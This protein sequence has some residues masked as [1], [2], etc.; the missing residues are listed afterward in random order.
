MT[1]KFFNKTVSILLTMIFL[2]GIFPP[3]VFAGPSSPS[4]RGEVKGFNGNVFD[5]SFSR[6]D[7]EINPERWLAEAKLGLSQAIYSWELIA[8]GLYEDPSL[9]EE[10]KNSLEK[11]GGE[12]L[13]ARFSDWLIGRFFGA[14]AEKTILEFSQNFSDTQKKYSWHLDGEGNVVFDD[15]TGDPLVIRPDEDGR[16]FSRDIV[17]WRNDAKTIINASSASHENIIARLF[18]ELLAYIPPEKRE[19]MTALIY[20]TVSVKNNAIKREFENIA[21]REERIFTSRRTRDIWS[22]RNKSENEAAKLFTEKLIAETGEICKAGIEELNVR[23]EQAEAGAGD[24]A[25]LGEEWL[26]LYREQF[27][28][29]LK[30]WEEAEERFFVRRIEWEQDSFKL[31]SEGE[32]VWLSAFKQF[33]EERK[34]WELN[35]KELFGAGEKLFIGLSEDFEKNIADAKKEFELNMA[36]RIEEGT[37]GVKALIDMYLTCASTAVSLKETIYYWQKEFCGNIYDPDDPEFIKQISAELKGSEFK[38]EVSDEILSLHTSYL[39]YMEKARDSRGRITANY[40]E[41]LGSG[42]LKDIL[43]PGASSEDFCLDEYQTAL[44]RAKALVLHWER[45]A[46]IAEAVENYAADLSAKR[47]TEAEGLRAWEEAKIAYNNS[48]AVYEAELIKLNEAGSDIQKQRDVLSA[49]SLEMQKEEEKLNALYDEYKSFLSL[50]IYKSENYYLFELN[51][52]YEKLVSGYGLFDKSG[53]KAVYYGVLLNGLMWGIAE[54]RENKNMERQESLEP[55]TTLLNLYGYGCETYF[56]PEA[57]DL[58]ETIFNMPGNFAQNAAKFLVD[59]EECFFAV[60]EWLK[61]E[62]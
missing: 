31:F 60:P 46:A 50:S 49:V 11:W 2:F 8:R 37:A 25:L 33:E 4:L 53:E 39:S 34:K 21:A 56:L 18:P 51:D 13:E 44:V 30:A 15:T 27:E 3:A 24:L 10:A 45:K 7:R 54:E 35:A 22:L 41:L 59:F 57:R 14:A 61:M 16:E 58:C 52:K 5:N 43:S 29:G 32:E 1:N 26:R 55:L 20:E 38:F 48:L 17:K 40:A 42:A 12:E 6:A 36:M 19:S 47:K 28:R 23:I 9:F 62:I